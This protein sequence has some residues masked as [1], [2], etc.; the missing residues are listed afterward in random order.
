MW[1]VRKK[2]LRNIKLVE[3]L[4][5]KISD[6]PDITE[7]EARKKAEQVLK[8]LAV[9]G[10]KIQECVRATGSTETES[11]GMLDGECETEVDILYIFSGQ[12]EI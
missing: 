12:K 2:I 5:N 11:W 9:T 6:A 4:K 7:D 1:P 8:D 10:M 3:K